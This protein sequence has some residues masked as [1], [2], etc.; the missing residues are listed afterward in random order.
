MRSPSIQRLLAE[1]PRLSR[2]EA[3]LI[4]QLASAVDNPDAL[5]QL[6]DNYL[7]KTA[8]YVRSLYSDPYNSRMWRRTVALEAMDEIMGTHGVEALG[9]NVGGP[10]PPPY[11]YL[12]TGDSYA[13]TLVY[14][15]KTD[16][17]SIGDWASIV[18]RH[19]NWP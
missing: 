18:E 16:T 5:S 8:R 15:R 4:K 9:P 7:P 6:V 19:P 11:E 14:T 17:L 12:N 13:A 1:F 2:G 3:N 10:N